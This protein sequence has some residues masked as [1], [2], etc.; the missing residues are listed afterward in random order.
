M[1]GTGVWNIARTVDH[2]TSLD[3]SGTIVRHI[4]DTI[5]PWRVAHEAAREVQRVEIPPSQEGD[6]ENAR[7]S[8]EGV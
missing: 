3:P 1:Y 2:L 5:S 7:A 4:S 8:T 6:T